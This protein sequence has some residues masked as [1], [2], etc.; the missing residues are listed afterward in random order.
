MIDDTFL[1]AGP[2]DAKELV[3]DAA[4]HQHHGYGTDHAVLVTDL[5]AS[6]L[7]VPNVKCTGGPMNRLGRPEKRLATP[8]SKADQETFDLAMNETFAADIVSLENILRPLVEQEAQPFLLS[9][10]HRDSAKVHKLQTLQGRDAR[11]VL[12]DIAKQTMS[13]LHKA[14]RLALDVCQVQVSNPSGLHYRPKAVGKRR[15]KLMNTLKK[16]RALRKQVCDGTADERSVLD[17]IRQARAALGLWGRAPNSAQSDPI[18]PN[19]T[20]ESGLRL[21][22]PTWARGDLNR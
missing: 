16:T 6:V 4:I 21:K 20:T 9:Q 22:A 15:R 5:N 11:E 17:F 18:R 1:L 13:L 3:V 12:E 14:H 8:V 7:A 2:F 19:S 10:Q